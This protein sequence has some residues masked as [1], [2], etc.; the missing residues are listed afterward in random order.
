M[1]TYILF[2]DSHIELVNENG[3]KL[4]TTT[5]LNDSTINDPTKPIEHSPPTS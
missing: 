3:D 5:I 1:K 4:D 2:H